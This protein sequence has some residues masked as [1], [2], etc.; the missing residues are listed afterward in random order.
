MGRK[1]NSRVIAKHLDGS[2]E[3]GYMSPK[4]MKAV[5]QIIV[6]ALGL[7]GP[8]D[9]P[10]AKCNEDQAYIADVS[11]DDVDMVKVKIGKVRVHWVCRSCGESYCTHHD[12]G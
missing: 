6:D 5:Q 4:D 11:F 1:T 7:D 12:G 10:C 9:N 3:H 2:T 8:C